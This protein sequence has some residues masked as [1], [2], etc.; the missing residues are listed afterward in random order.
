[1]LVYLHAAVLEK[2]NIQM[3]TFAIDKVRANLISMRDLYTYKFTAIK[4]IHLLTN[5]KQFID[6]NNTFFLWLTY[7]TL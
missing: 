3:R 5:A 4:Y 7:N 2:M 6:R 1:M